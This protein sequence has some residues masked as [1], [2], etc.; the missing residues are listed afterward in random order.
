[1]NKYGEMRNLR[2]CDGE[3]KEK[4]SSSCARERAVTGDLRVVKKR[5]V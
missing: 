2:I 5:L 1:M 4:G 3:M